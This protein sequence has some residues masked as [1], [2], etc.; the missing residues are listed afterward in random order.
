[1]KVIGI[2]DNVVDKY[3]DKNKMY[4]GGNALNF[5]VYSKQLG[6]DS[7]YLGVF[8]NDEASEHIRE[9]LMDLDIDISHCRQHEGENGY[10]LVNLVN[11]DRV[12]VGGNQGGV[13]K[14][15]PIHLGSM[16][17]EYIKEFQI[18][19]SSIY[20]GIEKELKKLKDTGILVSFDF[21]DEFNEQYLKEICPNIDF[22]LLSCGGLSEN[23]VRNLLKRV[24]SY[25]SSFA[26]GTMGGRGSIV[27]DGE[28]FYNQKPHF[29]EPV[30][31][32]GAGDSFFTAFIIHY[33]KEIEKVPF[34]EK[35][36]I[37]ERSL[38]EAAKFAAKTCLVEGAFGYGVPF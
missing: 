2:G 7:A 25:G 32:L 18:V 31:T 6:I 9:T 11:G 13:Q 21:S 20:S 10:A 4:P 24:H 36:P 33:L 28:S 14:D 38:D 15:F 8:G 22:S 30:D 1:M 19:H 16:D 29:V 3:M 34:A 23:E 17:L 12:F 35:G 5:G 26:I 37:I 27:Y